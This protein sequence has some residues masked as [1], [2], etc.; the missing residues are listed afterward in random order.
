MASHIGIPEK[1]AELTPVEKD[2]LMDAIEQHARNIDKGVNA[3][4]SLESDEVLTSV[5]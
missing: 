5:Q 3:T 4:M 1:E 2:K